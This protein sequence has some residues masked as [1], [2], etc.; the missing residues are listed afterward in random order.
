MS[1]IPTKS[2]DFRHILN[3][4]RQKTEQTMTHIQPF[5]YCKGSGF[6]YSDTQHYLTIIKHWDER[7]REGYNDNQSLV[8]VLFIVN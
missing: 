2:F 7:A 4:M 6:M 5:L 8:E 1:D 3:K